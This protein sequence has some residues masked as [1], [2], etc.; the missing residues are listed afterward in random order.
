MNQFNVDKLKE[1]LQSACTTVFSLYESRV[2]KLSL[3]FPGYFWLF[4]CPNYPLLPILAWYDFQLKQ[5]TTEKR[6]RM[7]IEPSQFWN[8]YYHLPVERKVGRSRTLS[9]CA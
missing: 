1:F 5:F 9:A 4:L 2:L 3:S 6:G 8:D 7:G